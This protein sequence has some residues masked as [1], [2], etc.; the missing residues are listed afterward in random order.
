M[1]KNTHKKL[2]RSFSPSNEEQVIN[3]FSHSNRFIHFVVWWLSM[4][5]REMKKIQCHIE[6]V[7]VSHKLTKQLWSILPVYKIVE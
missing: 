3:K 1:G 5:L 6:V 4:I 7:G 2:R